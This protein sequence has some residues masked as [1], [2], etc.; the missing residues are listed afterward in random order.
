M[1]CLVSTLNIREMLLLSVFSGGA[2]ELSSDLSA[3]PAVA[4]LNSR[5]FGKV[6]AQ[7][8]HIISEFNLFPKM[9][10]I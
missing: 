5:H 9:L 6:L 2:E 3:A 1:S 7:L 8:H 4:A 10:G